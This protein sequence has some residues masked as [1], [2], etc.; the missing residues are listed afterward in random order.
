MDSGGF[1]KNYVISAVFVFY[2]IVQAQ[3]ANQ[4]INC[5]NRNNHPQ[6]TWVPKATSQGWPR[7]CH[8]QRWQISIGH[9]RQRQ[10]LDFNR[11][12]KYMGPQSYNTILV[13]YSY[14]KR[15]QIPIGY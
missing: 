4:T 5:Q 8:I 11:L 3:W 10:Y 6:A 9:G 2:T 1:M 14:V 12:R 13:L 7:Y 15:W